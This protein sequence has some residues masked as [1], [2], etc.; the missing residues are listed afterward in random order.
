[1]DGPCSLDVGNEILVTS[2]S[3]TRLSV[4]AGELPCCRV[5][6]S[7]N[8]SRDVWAMSICKFSH[9]VR[10]LNIVLLRSNGLCDAC[11]RRKQHSDESCES[12]Q[13]ADP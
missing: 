4:S 13:A 12:V 8:L 7:V 11:I 6:T 5:I 10:N 9:L 3:P 2:E 1:M